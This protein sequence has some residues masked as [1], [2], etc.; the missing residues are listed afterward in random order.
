MG[1]TGDRVSVLGYGCM[2]YP[3]INGKIDEQRTERQIIQAIEQGVNYFDTA[4]IY[5]GGK[6]ESILGDV[7]AKGYRDRVR[8]A[9][10][11]PP[12][13]IRS[14]KD[15]ESVLEI[16]LG[17]LRTDRID[18]YLV[19][20]L[21]DWGTWDRLKKLGIDEFVRKAK[22]EGKIRYFGFSYH[23][24]R[25]VFKALVD[26]YPWDFCQIQY[27]YMDEHFQAGREGLEY[28]AS[29]GLGVIV[30]EPLRGGALVGKMPEEIRR[31]WE[32]ADAKRSAADWA[33]RWLWNQPEVTTVLSGLNEEAHIDENIRIANDTAPGSLTPKELE[34]YGEVGREYNRLMKVGCTG[35][36]YC[37]PCPAGVDIPLCF[38]YYNSK[39]LFKNNHAKWQY[40]GFTGGFMGGKPSYASLCKDCGKCEKVCPQHLPIREKLREV[41]GDM[42]MPVLKPVMWITRKYFTVRRKK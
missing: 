20:A 34:L 11:M 37:M 21:S 6:S 13:K 41:A 19:H 5:L 22:A 28:A 24:D 8:I 26:D 40:I 1:K 30:M 36:G 31:I 15:M 33:L 16:Q 4:Y 7:L 39:H 27:N 10:K 9:T 23:G 38:S 32:G 25:E 3:R 35:C 2:R 14:I 29:K 12:Y 17:R 42:E 18:Y